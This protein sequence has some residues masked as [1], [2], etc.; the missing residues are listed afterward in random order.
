MTARPD[1]GEPQPFHVLAKPAGAM[2]NLACQYCYFLSKQALYPGSDFRMSD[3]VLETYVRQLMAAH[4]HLPEVTVAWQGGEPALVGLDFYRRA[5]Q[6]VEAHRQQGQRVLYTIQTNGTLLDDEWAAFFRQ[7][8][9]LVGLSID[10]PRGLHDAYRVDRRGA[11]TF[12]RVKRGWDL[13]QRHGVDTNVLCAVHAANAGHPLEVYRFFRDGL[14][15]RFIQFIPIVE[16]VTPATRALADEGWGAARP[17]YVQE[18]RMVTRRSV[19]PVPWGR[20]LTRIFDEWV[21]RDVGSVYV[22]H[23]DAALAN[24]LGLPAGVCAFQETCGTAV[25]LEHSGD[26]YA[27]DHFV[28][29]GYLLGNI[30]DTPLAELVGSDRQRAFGLAKRDALPH[31]CRTCGVRFACHG[32]CPRNRFATAPGGEEGLSY[33]CAGYKLFF[34]Q[35]DAPMRFMANELRH[36]RSPAKVT[37]WVA[38]RD[39]AAES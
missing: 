10:G 5:A 8:D 34:E 3:R 20:F 6:L 32:E 19:E 28:E 33:L 30:L 27:C 26:L 31:A 39:T 23:F 36:H 37:H 17:L 21:R 1:Q 2:C 38:M 11:G 15:A 9:Y 4:R 13:L 12:Q 22:Q 18:G 16:R 25:V 7:H 24:W 29:P 14:G 35:I